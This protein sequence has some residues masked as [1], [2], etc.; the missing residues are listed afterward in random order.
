MNYPFMNYGNLIIGGDLNLSLSHAE[1]WGHQSQD[2]ILS[3]FFYQLIESHHLIEIDVVKL[4]PTWRNHRTGE[5]AIAQRSDH[6][7]LKEAL[8][9]FLF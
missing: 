6:F 9:D 4:H 3:T 5:E 7:F 2:G 1:C 8:L